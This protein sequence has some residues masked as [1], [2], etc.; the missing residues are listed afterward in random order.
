LYELTPGSANTE[1]ARYL[2]DLILN[3][4]R[5]RRLPLAACYVRTFP[6]GADVP[7]DYPVSTEFQAPAAPSPEGGI[8]VDLHSPSEGR[9]EG[10]CRELLKPR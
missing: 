8:R 10:T 3:N 2:K 7:L 5:F 9:F 1:K 6:F 4:K